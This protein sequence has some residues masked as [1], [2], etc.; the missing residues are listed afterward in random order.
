MSRDVISVKA[1]DTPDHARQL[2]LDHNIRTLPVIDE[3]GALV[4]T[5]GLRE[6]AQAAGAVGNH[7]ST[8]ATAVPEQA[9]MRLVPV[10]SDGQKHAVIIVDDQRRVLGLI[11]QTDLL[12]AL[13]RHVLGAPIPDSGL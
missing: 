4:G 7:I 12:A 1:D 9:A 3:S 8:P 13:A 11:T 10:L 6:L 2:L 5:V